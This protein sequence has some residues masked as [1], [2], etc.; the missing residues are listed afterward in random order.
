MQVLLTG[1]PALVA[2]AATLL[3][4]ALRNN[5]PALAALYQTGVFYFA[6]AYCG[7]NL[8][9]MARLFHV[10]PSPVSARLPD[11]ETPV[12]WELALLHACWTQ[13]GFSSECCFFGSLWVQV[14]RLLQASHLSQQGRLSAPGLGLLA[15]QSFLG[16]L[17]PESLL[18]VLTTQ[19]PEAFAAAMVGDVDNPE[20]IWTHRMRGQRLVPQARAAPCCARAFLSLADRLLITLG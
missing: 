4:E 2:G 15:Q 5:R 17:L 9:E 3:E 7:S 13:C 12:T 19:G 14:L 11:T 1:E 6:L 8:I 18:Y 16:G 10:R 20:L